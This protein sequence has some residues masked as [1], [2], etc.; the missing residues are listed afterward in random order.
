[1]RGCSLLDTQTQPAAPFLGFNNLRDACST[2]PIDLFGSPAFAVPPKGGAAPSVCRN[3]DEYI[4][5]DH[6]RPS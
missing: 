2:F 3:P 1:M 4:F 5:W 6:V